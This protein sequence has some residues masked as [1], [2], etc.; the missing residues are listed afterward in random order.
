[1]PTLGTKKFW[2]PATG[3][4]VSQKENQILK[5]TGYIN[6]QLVSVNY[7]SSGNFFQNIFGGEDQIALATNLKYQT[8][9]DSIEAA[10]VQDVKTVRV[11]RNYILGLQRYIAVKIPGHSDALSI[12]VKITAVKNDNLQAK[13]EMLNQPEYQSA[14]QLAPTIVGQVLTITSLTK[15]LFTD[16]DP[17]TQLDASYGGIISAQAEEHPVSNGKLTKG[18]LIM[19]S[20]DDGDAYD[21]VDESKFEMRGDVLYYDDKEVSNTYIV[22]NISFDPLKGD[23]EQSNWYKKYNE[24]LNV[25]D[26]IQI[27]EDN[28]EWKKIYNDA[29]NLWIE[30]NALLDADMTY[31][32]SEKVKIKSAAIKLVNEKYNSLNIHESSD[33]I[34]AKEILENIIRNTDSEALANALP[35]TGV[36]LNNTRSAVDAF[37]DESFISTNG[38]ENDRLSQMITED[39]DNY[40]QALK[41]NDLEFRLGRIHDCDGFFMQDDRGLEAAVVSCAQLPAPWVGKKWRVAGSLKT[42]LD[43]VN[44]LAPARSKRSDGTIGDV[45]HAQRSSDHNPWVLDSDGSSGIVTAMDIT[46]DPVNGCDCH[47]LA[48]SLQHN[49][50]KR[51][52]YVIWNKRIMSSTVSPWE[53]RTYTGSNPH[54]KH[55]H[56]STHCEKSLRDLNDSWAITVK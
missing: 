2:K 32:N 35:K 48:E 13:F 27:T 31:I 52:K 6:I 12:D 45:A 22:F 14:L 28:S 50:D 46:H 33:V 15:K 20:T 41:D 34:S 19:V 21:D 49:K 1:M 44:N 3:A 53:W 11:N 36:F 51:I 24:A 10:S 47:V 42:I 29:K 39:T 37:G 23:D 16:T 26:K 40:L 9:V 30:G 25:L 43:Q 54:N 55:L 4:S 38:D 18:L 5:N 7:M 17:Q 56:I 8:G